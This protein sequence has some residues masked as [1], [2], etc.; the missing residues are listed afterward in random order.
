METNEMEERL[1]DELKELPGDRKKEIYDLIH[2]FILGIKAEERMENTK[3]K[4]KTFDFRSS[5]VLGIWKDREEFADPR[6][7]VKARRDEWRKRIT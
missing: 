1:I 7:W 6:K 5:N 4:K 2:Y 3:Q